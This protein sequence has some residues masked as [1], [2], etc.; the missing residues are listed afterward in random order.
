MD[1]EDDCGSREV[2]AV[3]RQRLFDVELFKLGEGFV[4]EDLAFQHFVD[5]GFKS[6][7]HDQSY[8]A[9]MI[10]L[11]A[12]MISLYK[13]NLASEGGTPAKLKLISFLKLFSG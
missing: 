2:L 10:N 8:R 11:Q 5:Q 13:D 3:F 4:E 6:G 12:R 7:T 9:R 1:A